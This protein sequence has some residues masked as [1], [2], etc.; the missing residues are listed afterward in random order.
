MSGGD[1]EATYLG[2]TATGQC[3]G[4]TGVA[5]S[6]VVQLAGDADYLRFDVQGQGDPTLLINGPE[7]WLCSDDVA[8]LM[9]RIDGSFPAGTYRIWVG[10]VRP[11]DEQ[12]YVLLIDQTPPEQPPSGGELELDGFQSEYPS[13]ALTPGFWPDPQTLNGTAEGAFDARQLGTTPQGPCVGYLSETPNHILTINQPFSYLRIH[14]ESTGD[15]TLAVNG[16][17]GWMCND[18][19]VGLQPVVEG[20][21]RQGTYRVWVG[22]ATPGASENYQLQVSQRR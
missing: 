5:P 18:D 4:H 2:A 3:L 17:D 16:P 22:T 12:G 9:P 19:Q 14:A 7:G 21:F 6:H 15:T 13:L 8:G 1:I 10:S 11:D 20:G